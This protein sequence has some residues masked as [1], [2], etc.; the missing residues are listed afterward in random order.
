[1]FAF[2]DHTEDARW[3]RSGFAPF[4]PVSDR[5]PALHFAFDVPPPSALVSLLAVVEVPAA[6]AAAQP[7]VWEYWGGR[8]WTELSVRDATAG[9]TRTDLIQFVGPPD[10]RPREGLGGALYRVRARLKSGLAS[11]DHRAQLGGAWLNAVW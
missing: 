8:G 6:E 2:T 10:A 5:T 3:P 4:V 11:M 7:F 9:L 1:D